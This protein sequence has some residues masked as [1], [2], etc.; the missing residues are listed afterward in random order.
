MTL[1][2]ISQLLFQAVLLYCYFTSKLITLVVIATG[3]LSPF[4][5]LSGRAA[6]KITAGG[7]G[8]PYTA[9]FIRCVLTLSFPI[10]L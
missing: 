1:K 9:N 5:Q 7:L 6:A 4:L 8:D 2:D 10:P 3:P